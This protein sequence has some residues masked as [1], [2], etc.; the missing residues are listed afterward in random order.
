[1]AAPA[2][3]RVWPAVRREAESLQPHALE[4]LRQFIRFPTV[5]SDTRRREDIARAS[6]WLARH[7]H[8]I[9]ME[10]VQVWRTGGHP[11]VYADW[12]RPGPRRTILVYGH[13]D[14]VPAE[15][16]DGWATDP[17]HPTID[18]DHLIGR[19]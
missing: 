9:G 1:M 5:S 2:T 10:R 13:Y 14:V 8:R 7:L 16:S 6:A 12:I 3:K 19:G 15:K 11:A 17:F 4:S 18:G